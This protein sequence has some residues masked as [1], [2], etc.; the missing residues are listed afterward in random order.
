MK[1]AKLQ[2]GT[3]VIARKLL[4]PEGA[5]VEPGTPGVVFEETDAYGDG[6]GPMVR[7]FTGTACNVYDGDVRVQ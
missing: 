6:A 5:D 3:V 7:W 1:V 2:R 4:D